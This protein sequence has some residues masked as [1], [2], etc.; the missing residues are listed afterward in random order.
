[1]VPEQQ[2][3]DT[4]KRSFSLGVNIV[5]TAPDYAGADDLVVEAINASGREVI[6]C[7]QGYGC[8]ALFEHFFETA[9]KKLRK[10]RLEMFGIACVDDREKLGENVWG[11][12]G[13]VEFLEMKKREGRLIGTFCTT[14]GTPEYICRLLDSDVFDAIMVAYNPAGY[15]LLSYNP[16]PP[17][18][19]EC[20][21]R[22]SEL[23]PIFARRD[24]GLMVMKPLAGGLLCRGKA[25]KPHNAIS[26]GLTAHDVLRFLLIRHPEVASVLPGTNSE[27][28]AEENARA[29]YDPLEEQPDASGRVEAVIHR[30]NRSVCSRCGK[31]DSLCSEHLPVSWLFRAAYIDNYRSM[32]FETLGQ[33][34]YFALHPWREVKC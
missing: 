31:C 4:L 30:M 24:V 34:R 33:H 17:A 20:L 16:E 10:K 1:M 15:H 12:G 26:T 28:E 6:V 18:Q 7:T 21:A 13:M 23:F 25:F 9:S 32:P 5:H 3:I 14:H 27:A 19:S 29:G 22:N 2:A 8:R 11:K